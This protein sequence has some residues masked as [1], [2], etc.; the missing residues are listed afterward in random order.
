MKA[1]VSEVQ[2]LA[3]GSRAGAGLSCG[4]ALLILASTC[5][6][7]YFT[8]LEAFPAIDPAEGYYVEAA[9][10][11]VEL[12]NYIVPYLN[13]QIYFSKPILTFWLIAFSYKLFG[14]SEW[15][16]RLPF[17]LL[18]SLL[19]FAVFWAT[20]ALS[21]DSREG[22]VPSVRAGLIAGLVLASAPLLLLVSRTSPVD[23]AFSVFL[24]LAVLG[25]AV[26]LAGAT[27]YAFL[28]IYTGLALALLAKG[29][30]AL[31][32][33]GIAAG[34]FLLVSRPSLKEFFAWLKSLKPLP[35][36]LVFLAV[37]LPWHYLVYKATDGL[38]LKVFFLYENL[39]RFA[40]HTNMGK[41][42]WWFFIP[43]ILVGFFPFIL[44]LPQAMKFALGFGRGWRQ[45]EADSLLKRLSHL[46]MEP[47]RRIKENERIR[48]LA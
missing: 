32:L 20:R 6:L 15:A 11:M 38:F 44:L 4:R 24:C 19:V 1:I 28:L 12:G 30:A 3:A 35:G 18:S 17:A 40:G 42:S 33:Y 22:E 29:P 10:E 39:A 36:A 25:T 47:A 41:M 48:G 43:T 45:G 23:I 2:E 5:F 9:R 37:A 34:G 27:S 7:L 46:I 13:D 31:L 16:A 26:S 21:R 14:F 8:G